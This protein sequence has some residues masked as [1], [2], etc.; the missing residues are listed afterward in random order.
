MNSAAAATRLVAPPAIKSATRRSVA[1]S[2]L[3]SAGVMREGTRWTISPS[4]LNG[5][6]LVAGSERP[7]AL[8]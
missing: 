3:P 6:R 8:G 2:S 1:V 5:S 4:M 7:S